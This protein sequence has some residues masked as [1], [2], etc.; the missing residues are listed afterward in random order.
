MRM[1]DDVR[2]VSLHAEPPF[3]G[4]IDV[5]VET[6]PHAIVEQVSR[7]CIDAVNVSTLAC[8]PKS[9]VTSTFITK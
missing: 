9:Q 7:L 3:T 8:G 4:S 5:R 2:T 1:F 6:Q